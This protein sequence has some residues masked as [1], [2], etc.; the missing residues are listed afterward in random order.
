MDWNASLADWKK[1]KQKPQPLQGPH[2]ESIPVITPKNI[3]LSTRPAVRNKVEGG[4]STIRSAGFDLTNNPKGPVVLIPTVF[5]NKIDYSRN[6]TPSWNEYQRTGQHL[7]VYPG[8]DAAL[9][10]ASALHLT[11]E[12][13]IGKKKKSN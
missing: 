4:T 11:E 6:L 2:G 5:N 13:R 9:A 1:G 8:R 12:N 7:G 10:A 3:N